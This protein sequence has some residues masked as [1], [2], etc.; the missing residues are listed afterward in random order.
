VA[1]HHAVPDSERKNNEQCCADEGE[2]KTQA[3]VA[4]KQEEDKDRDKDRQQQ[5]VSPQPA[6]NSN[7][8]ACCYDENQPGTFRGAGEAVDC[9]QD[10]KHG[11]GVWKK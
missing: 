6:G 4:L 10:W 11:E 9:Q 3:Q 2:R 5:S 1:K 7:Q 8:R